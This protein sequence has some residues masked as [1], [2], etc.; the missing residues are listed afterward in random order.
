MRKKRALYLSKNTIVRSWLASY[1][2]LLLFVS[3][4][5]A[6]AYSKAIA[7]AMEEVEHVYE[8]ELRRVAAS[9]D[10]SML[11]MRRI[12]QELSIDPEVYSLI[13]AREVG[14][15]ERMS[16]YS[17][18]KRLSSYSV[19]NQNITDVA[20]GLR[21]LDYV[22]SNRTTYSLDFYAD[23]IGGGDAMRAM[24]GGSRADGIYVCRTLNQSPTVGYLMNLP[25]EANSSRTAYVQVK[26]SCDTLSAILG[27]DSDRML[28]LSVGDDTL[29]IGDLDLID[30]PQESCTSL[31]CPSDFSGLS[32]TLTV[33]N[34]EFQRNI[35]AVNLGTTVCVLL[36]I[37]VCSF[38]LIYFIRRN[39]SPVGQLL[40]A[41]DMTFDRLP[42]NYKNEFDFIQQKLA[43]IQDK[44]EKMELTIDQTARFR[45]EA[46]V[47]QLLMGDISAEKAAEAL[48]LYPAG[49]PGFA[50]AAVSFLDWRQLFHTE[51][52]SASDNLALLKFIVSNMMQDFDGDALKSYGTTIGGMYVTLFCGSPEALHSALC[53]TEDFPSILSSVFGAEVQIGMSSCVPDA[54]SIPELYDQAR[55]A[56]EFC[57]VF[58]KPFQHFRTGCTSGLNHAQFAAEIMQANKNFRSSL[59]QGDFG[60]ASQWLQE[61]MGLCFDQQQ[62]VQDVQASMRVLSTIFCG[63]LA[64]YKSRYH[65]E[66]LDVGAIAEELASYATANQLNQ[67][68]LERLDA[69]KALAIARNS[70]EK[71]QLREELIAYIE[72]NCTRYDLTVSS[73]SAYFN[74]TVSSL[75]QKFRKIT[76]MG[77]LEYI[78]QAKIRKAKVLLETRQYT[79]S[80]IAELVGYNDASTF[81]RN[82][83]KVESISPGRYLQ[84]LGKEATAEDPQNPANA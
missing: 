48:D 1:L 31:T 78:T 3:F 54:G 12:G 6:I 27:D 73:M 20:I 74:M 72:K 30:A 37:G 80:Q 41:V 40:R 70:E 13:N 32:Y 69:L 14:A 53:R 7:Y 29:R 18:Q 42:Q 51:N 57:R 66:N 36:C 35:A 28:T 52:D 34:R 49:E 8:Q 25:L 46:A 4:F 63:G 2:L 82:F 81:I 64:E 67:A 38:V 24:I 9:L 19:T 43:L 16:F 55:E 58:D 50:A 65:A 75:S 68:L 47:T 11:E 60:G 17:L 10:R 77:V 22:V 45:R 79:I 44:N 23:N 33:D 21:S 61:L 59:A 76:G 5:A 15:D 39:Y 56:A 71:T 26:L 62:S 84:E 83:K